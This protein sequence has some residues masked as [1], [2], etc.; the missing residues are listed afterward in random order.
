ME[1][2]VPA[3]QTALQTTNLSLNTQKGMVAKLRTLSNQGFT[4][5]ETW[6]K[7]AKLR[8]L[9]NNSINVYLKSLKKYGILLDYKELQGIKSLP[10]NPTKRTYL[11]ISEI[12]RI[13]G[14]TVRYRPRS[15]ALHIRYNVYF[16]IL[17]FCGLRVSEAANLTTNDIDFQMRTITVHATKTNTIRIVPISRSLYPL[18]YKYVMSLTATELFP[19]FNVVSVNQE[20]HKRRKYLGITRPNLCPYSF[21]HSFATRLIDAN[22]SLFCVKALLGHKDINMTQ[23][24][25][26]ESLEMLREGVNKDP[27]MKA[28]KH[29]RYVEFTQKIKALCEQY[30]SLN[31][32][33]EQNPSGL[34]L[35]LVKP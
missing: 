29:E 5:V 25:Y 32:S 18:L 33:Y 24:Y 6:V 4:D 9:T 17:A 3:F 19:K 28:N 35:S 27:L 13:C 16:S 14:I 23:R 26:H 34:L 30:S 12:N 10:D 15:K 8:G 1:F 7:E 22:T 2:N 11:T 31:I 21:G 20:F